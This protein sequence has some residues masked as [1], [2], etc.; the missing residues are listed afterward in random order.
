VRS[1]WLYW[2]SNSTSSFIIR[3]TRVSTLENRT[4]I[5]TIHRVRAK[6]LC[7]NQ[8]GAFM[9][10][11]LQAGGMH[12]QGRRADGAQA[13]LG[14]LAQLVLHLPSEDVAVGPVILAIRHQRARRHPQAGGLGDARAVRL[15]RRPVGAHGQ[16]RAVAV[17]AIE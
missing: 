4:T 5:S 10:E 8:K 13:H 2:R 9:G 12:P 11:G 7:G 3:Y 6:K 14:V 1:P 16:R 15:G 17:L